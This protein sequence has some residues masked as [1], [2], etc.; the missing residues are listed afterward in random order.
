MCKVPIGAL[1]YAGKMLGSGSHVAGLVASNVPSF[2]H[3]GGSGK[4]VELRLDSVL[5][6]QRRMME[7]R[8]MTLSRAGEALII[9][10]FRSTSAERKRAGVEAGPIS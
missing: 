1:V 7:R 5:E 4:M 10:A 8:G 6:T 2:T 3:L 9:R